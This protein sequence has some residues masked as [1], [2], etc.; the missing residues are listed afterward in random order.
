MSFLLYWRLI[1]YGPNHLSR[2]RKRALGL[3]L[4]GKAKVSV[5]RKFMP[6]N[7]SLFRS[8]LVGS[9]RSSLHDPFRFLLDSRGRGPLSAFSL[10]SCQ[11]D[12][13]LFLKSLEMDE[14]GAVS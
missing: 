9:R 3:D 6:F 5:W 14:D 7:F 2:C 10:T 13:S 8:D 1:R 4:W 12:L 11:G